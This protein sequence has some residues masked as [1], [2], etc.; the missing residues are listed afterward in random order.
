MKTK[1]LLQILLNSGTPAQHRINLSEMQIA[2]LQQNPDATEKE[3]DKVYTTFRIFTL[4]L[5]IIDEQN[6][7]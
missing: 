3:K 1:K 7:S 5:Q 4:I 6:I 2:Y